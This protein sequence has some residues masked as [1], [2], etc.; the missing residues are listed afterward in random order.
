MKIGNLNRM[1]KGWFI[2][3]FTPSLC[4]TNACE[5]A[6]KNYKAGTYESKHYHKIATEYTV[7]ISGRV[8]MFDTEFVAGDIVICEPGDATDFLAIED[9][10]NVVVKLPGVNNDKY[11]CMEDD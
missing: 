9:A 11:L 5:I 2:G 4:K 10:V 8:K 7:I 1:Y 6:V 3:N